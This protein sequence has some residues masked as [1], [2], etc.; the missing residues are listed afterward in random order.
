[1]SALNR[2]DKLW[3]E[4]RLFELEEKGYFQ[5]SSNIVNQATGIFESHRSPMG[6]A[7][8]IILGELDYCLPIMH[9]APFPLKPRMPRETEIFQMDGIHGESESWERTFLGTY[10]PKPLPAGSTGSRRGVPGASTQSPITQISM[11]VTS[12]SSS[13]AL[14]LGHDISPPPSPASKRHRSSASSLAAVEDEEKAVL[15]TMNLGNMLRT[16]ED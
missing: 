15:D 6:T 12:V 1:L 13:L 16:D 10:T 7:G 11:P 5:S 2:V 8:I 4:Q 9:C 14:P 3:I